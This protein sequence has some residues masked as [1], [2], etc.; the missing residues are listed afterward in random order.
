MNNFKQELDEARNQIRKLDAAYI[1][2][3]KSESALAQGGR[4]RKIE[5]GKTWNDLLKTL[6]VDL[7][8]LLD[9]EKVDARKAETTHKILE[10]SFN[11]VPDQIVQS[12]K[13]QLLIDEHLKATMIWDGYV[14]E[15]HWL[16]YSLPYDRNGKVE[17]GEVGS[18]GKVEGNCGIVPPTSIYD[19]IMKPRSYAVGAGTGWEDQHS[20]SVKCWFWYYISGKFAKHPGTAYIWPYFDIHGNYWVRSNDGYFTSK[21][22]SIK[23]SMTTRVFRPDHSYSP[24]F[25]WKVLDK[26][27]DNIDENGRVDFTGWNNSAKGESQVEVGEPLTVQVIAELWSYVEGSGSHALLDFQTGDSNS[28]RIP[29]IRVWMP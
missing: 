11:T 14:P 23:L 10:K 8:K 15:S 27:N 1:E 5:D 12:S 19:T 18:D 16:T 29:F 17:F 28:I 26:S 20:T 4:K 9:H 3:L 24:F 6:N 2:E 7:S 21:E 13:E 25:T 22:A